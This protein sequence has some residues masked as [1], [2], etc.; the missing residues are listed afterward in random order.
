MGFFSDLEN[1]RVAQEVVK[2][3]LGVQAAKATPGR[4]II[5]ALSNPMSQAEITAEERS[6]S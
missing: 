5:F 1:W 3:M 6:V 2:A 4:P